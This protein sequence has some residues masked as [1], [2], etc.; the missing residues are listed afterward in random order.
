[1][2]V[3]LIGPD[4]EEN[5]SLRYLSAS[6]LAAGHSAAIVPFE[7]S[8]DIDR[9]RAAV[10]DADLIGLSMCYQIRAR[11][12]LELARALKADEPSRRIVAGGHYASCE[13]RS[14][15]EHHAA[16]DAIAVHE[17]ERT[18]VELAA[19]GGFSESELSNVP[20]LVFRSA[21]GIAATKPR[22]TL[23]DLDELPWP[24]RTGPARL[25]V[26]VPTA[27]LM[28]SR[29]CF[30][31]CDYCCITTLHRMVPG[32]RFRQR[33]TDDIAGEMASLYRERGVRQFVFH[34]D[35]FLVPSMPHN[36]ARIDAL[37]SALRRQ[38]VRDI[39]LVLKCRPG[40]VD[41][42]VFLHLR[43]MGL[44]RVFLGIESGTAEGL[45]S[46]GRDQT[47][48]QAHRALEICEE[49][50]ISTQYT[51][52][53]FHP[54]ATLRTIRADLEF[55][56][57][58][59]AHPLSFCRAEAYAGTPLEQKLIASGRAL[60]DYLHRTYRFSDPQTE[61][62]WKYSRTALR[63]RLWSCDH[64]LGRVVHLDHLAAV[65]RHFYEGRRVGELASDFLKWQLD[66]NRDSVDLFS[67]MIAAVE[68][69]GTDSPELERVAAEIRER[70][71]AT[72]EGFEQRRLVLREA[73]YEESFRLVGLTRPKRGR[74][75]PTLAP[76]RA[77]HAAAV[78]VAIGLIGCGDSGSGGT[79]VDASTDKF[80]EPDG[81][82]EA[83]PYDA[84]Q[85]PEDAADAGDDA[86][87]G[88][89][90]DGDSGYIEDSGVFEA[91]PYDG[92]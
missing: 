78:F 80:I 83:P 46:I 88:E 60:G 75:K 81:V 52:I 90:S 19:L 39:G 82:Y 37:E 63:E 66:V 61:L 49:L 35:N 51:M 21:S 34:D 25:V 41:R 67:D 3:A 23:A 27:Y 69:A 5:L 18:I 22:P 43:E 65:F 84:Y 47:V 20:G 2:H 31:A 1:M 87:A 38:G 92:G 74:P 14:L 7:K 59:L 70:E 85:P 30:G 24:D 44:L 28:G 11:E 12:F 48:A 76:A 50:D 57:A 32:K 72:H 36:H 13:A 89:G 54:E 15:L 26:G 33:S 40:E 73:I 71:Q 77:R 10:R 4:L 8:A 16:I 91:P 58:H 9:V 42:D 86:D 17:G 53:T 68:L 64:L 29:G 55:V 6:L 56:R 79:P 45:R 62:L